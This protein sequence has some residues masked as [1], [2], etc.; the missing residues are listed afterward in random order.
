MG[1]FEEFLSAKQRI[2]MQICSRNV[3]KIVVE[4]NTIYV[5]RTLWVQQNG[6]DKLDA[7]YGEEDATANTPKPKLSGI[8][9][10]YQIVTLTDSRLVLKPM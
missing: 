4:L 5:T 9:C 1:A 6:L 7:S 10:D 8:E 2:D 3:N